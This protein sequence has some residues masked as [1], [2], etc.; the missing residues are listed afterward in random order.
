MAIRMRLGFSKPEFQTLPWVDQRM[1]LEQLV[2]LDYEQKR[3]WYEN[4]SE[5]DQWK[6][7]E[8]EMPEVLIREEEML[9]LDAPSEQLPDILGMEW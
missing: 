6:Y 4:L 5:E 7:D 3:D 9:A 2:I 8:P 1:Y